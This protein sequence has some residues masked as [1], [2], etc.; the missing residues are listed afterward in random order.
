[1]QSKTRVESLMSA[2][3]LLPVN[4]L[5]DKP[6]RFPEYQ[7]DFFKPGGL[8]PGSTNADRRQK[9][10]SEK[11]LQSVRV[12]GKLTW[13]ERE[14]LEIINEDKRQFNE[15]DNWENTIFKEANPNWK[16]PDKFFENDDIFNNQTNA[17]GGVAKD[18]KKPAKKK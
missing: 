16:D 6:Y 3:N 18:S 9:K 8:I 10:A 4:S 11:Q 14:H 5:G 15:L 17:K 13:K 2:R 7:A 12:P 1:M